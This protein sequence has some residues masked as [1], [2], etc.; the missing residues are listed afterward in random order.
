ML[1]NS[2][3]IAAA[4]CLSV[5]AFACTSTKTI[6]QNQEPSHQKR[7]GKPPQGEKPKFAD[8]LTK[9]DKDKNG[10]LSKSEIEGPL[11]NDFEKIDA[12][13][14]GFITEAEL[15]KAGPPNPPRGN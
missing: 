3:K 7:E 8:L 1:K 15:K 11:K 13:K 6:A 4:I 5:I 12:N 9:M 10:K 14:D 2:L